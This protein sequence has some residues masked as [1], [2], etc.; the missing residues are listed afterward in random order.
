MNFVIVGVKTLTRFLEVERQQASKLTTQESS[1]NIYNVQI[2]KV[3]WFSF[4]SLAH[5]RGWS[6]GGRISKFLTLVM[7]RQKVRL[8]V[9]RRGHDYNLNS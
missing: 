9:S 7:G 6:F 5:S 4:Q 2:Q 1:V 3:Y 8:L